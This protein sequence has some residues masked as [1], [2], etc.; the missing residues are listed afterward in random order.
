[1][2]NFNDSNI[3]GKCES[4]HENLKNT[5]SKFITPVTN[6]ATKVTYANK[7]CALCNNDKNFVLWNTT[8]ECDTSDF[9][10]YESD[11]KL[12][13]EIGIFY[14]YYNGTRALCTQYRKPP[15]D[16]EVLKRI[17][18]YAIGACSNT[19]DKITVD[20]CKS[21]MSIVYDNQ[22]N[23]YKNKHCAACNGAKNVVNCIDEL[24]SVEPTLVT[25]FS[26]VFSVNDK[27]VGSSNPSNPCDSIDEAVKAKFCSQ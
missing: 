13:E 10:I 8:Y 24:P 19:T 3:R 23:V 20:L 12:D 27:A 2:P 15:Q 6:S 4:W 16:V 18:T 7:Y 22:F 1:M 9:S 14:K 11:V 5:D 21:F 25:A 17:C 26:S